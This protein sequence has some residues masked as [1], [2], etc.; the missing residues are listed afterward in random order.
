MA[1]ACGHALHCF[2]FLDG[3]EEKEE[4]KEARILTE[5]NSIKTRIVIRHIIGFKC[6]AA[7]C[8]ASRFSKSDRIVRL[9]RKLI[10]C[11]DNMHSRLTGFR[12]KSRSSADVTSENLCSKDKRKVGEEGFCRWNKLQTGL[13]GSANRFLELKAVFPH[14]IRMYRLQKDVITATERVKEPD[15]DNVD[16]MEL[17]THNFVITKPDTKNANA[18]QLKS[19]GDKFQDLQ[20][21]RASTENK[22]EERK[23]GTTTTP[24]HPKPRLPETAM[25]ERSPKLK[26]LLFAKR[27]GRN[28][29]RSKVTIS[30][31]SLPLPCQQRNGILSPDPANAGN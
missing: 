13:Q 22:Y 10:E 4:E 30:N 23:D 21:K 27:K 26:D 11:V 7:R 24:V 19:S 15:I 25:G 3:E 2:P 28:V 8:L 1:Y 17:D 14:C 29:N 16:I 9:A 12:R 31:E 6:W 5:P 20:E 18:M